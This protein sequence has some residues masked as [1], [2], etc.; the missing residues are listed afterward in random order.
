LRISHSV[1]S[2]LALPLIIALVL[3][4]SVLL[5]IGENPLDIFALMA[6]ESFGN[7]R[8][9]AATLSAAT[10]LFFTAVATAIC[11]R[12]GVF[13]VGVDGAFLVGGLCRFFAARSTWLGSDPPRI[14]R[15]SY[16]GC[17][18]AFPAWLSAGQ[19]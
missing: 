7:A 17:D 4:G 19:I 8:R 12:S 10:P 14:F 15:S 11:F 9:I 13:N 18:L 1:A 2:G 3:S 6:T 16:R 5:I